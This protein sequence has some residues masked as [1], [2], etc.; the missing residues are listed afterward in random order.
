MGHTF[1]YRTMLL[2]VAFAV[3]NIGLPVVLDTCP[4]AKAGNSDLCAT[5][6]NESRPE[7]QTVGIPGGSCCVMVVV[8]DRNT[9]EFEQSRDRLVDNVRTMLASAL[10]IPHLLFPVQFTPTT[11]G[12]PVESPPAE[13][14]IPILNSSLLI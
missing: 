3:F 9:T 8:G 14:D 13:P 11:V 6:H 10:E 2:A 1:K 4:M 5:C 12:R 7:T